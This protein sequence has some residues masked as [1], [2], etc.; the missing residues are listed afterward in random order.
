M[1]PHAQDMHHMLFS[2]DGID[3]PMLN[4]DSA[5]IISLKITHQFF[6]SWRCHE[7]ILCQQLKQLSGRVGK[8]GVF[9]F[10]DILHSVP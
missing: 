8:S 3:E 4:I 5:R 7:W 6:I 10:F 2:V 9:Q 1:G